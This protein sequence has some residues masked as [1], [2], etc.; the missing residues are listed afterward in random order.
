V[1]HPIA[2]T[3]VSLFGSLIA[4]VF[5]LYTLV[6]QVFGIRD[7]H[8]VTTGRAFG[9]VAVLFG[10]GILLVCGCYALMVFAAIGAIR[11][12]GFF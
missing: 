9:A 3:V 7:V 5:G 11:S 4:M 8:Q 2:Y 1:W 12:S 6:L 10:V